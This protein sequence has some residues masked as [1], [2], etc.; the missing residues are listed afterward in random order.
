MATSTATKDGQLMGAEIRYGSTLI[1]HVQELSRDP[2]SQRVRR[3]ITSYGPAGAEWGC[4]WN[5]LSSALPS[6]WS[7]VLAY[8]RSMISP[9][10]HR[11][12]RGRAHTGLRTLWRHRLRLS[13]EYRSERL[14]QLVL[15]SL[16]MQTIL[17]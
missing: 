7:S 3:L 12:D 15:R 14:T 13:L 8:V 16:H 9:I 5:G 2:I 10:G 4:Q 1:G 6:G 11:R 17:A